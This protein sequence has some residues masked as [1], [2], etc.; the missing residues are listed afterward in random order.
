[1]DVDGI[2]EVFTN[3]LSNALKFTEKGSIEVGVL[4]KETRIECYVKDSGIG[5]P[6]EHQP[7]LFSKFKQFGKPVVEEEKGTGL[8]LFIVKEILRRH[9]GTLSVSSEPGKGATFSFTL[10]KCKLENMAGTPGK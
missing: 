3:L 5:I 1:V 2:T 6:K 7:E 8:G 9:N 4:E 10:P